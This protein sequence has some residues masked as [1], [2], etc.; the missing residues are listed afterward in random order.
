[1]WRPAD[2]VFKSLHNSFRV[3]EFSIALARGRIN[4]LFGAPVYGGNITI[5]VQ[6]SDKDSPPSRKYRRLALIESD[7]SQETD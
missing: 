4:N 3:M 5:D 2:L 7:S 1:M 6:K